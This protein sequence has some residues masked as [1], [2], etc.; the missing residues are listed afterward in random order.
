M[1]L[2]IFS[3]T[4][5]PLSDKSSKST[6]GQQS[7]QDLFEFSLFSLPGLYQCTLHHMDFE[8]TEHNFIARARLALTCPQ[9]TAHTSFSSFSEYSLTYFGIITIFHQHIQAKVKI[10]AFRSYSPTGPSEFISLNQ[11]MFIAKVASAAVKAVI[12]GTSEDQL[13]LIKNA[14]KPLAGYKNNPTIIDYIFLQL[15]VGCFRKISPPSLPEYVCAQVL[16]GN[17]VLRDDA[18]EYLESYLVLMRENRGET[19]I[20]TEYYSALLRSD[21]NLSWEVRTKFSEEERKSKKIGRILRILP[22]IMGNINYVDGGLAYEEL[23]KQINQHIES[24]EE[25]IDKF[26]DCLII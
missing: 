17:C 25:S 26:N 24:F 21:K 6:A 19:L 3:Q 15:K 11:F 1:D 7:L 12:S 10:P 13:E 2:D 16:K 9:M 22:M 14:I 8:L 5:I 18:K 23:R 4:S 20:P